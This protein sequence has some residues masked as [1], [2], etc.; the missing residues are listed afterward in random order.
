MPGY[1]QPIVLGKPLQRDLQDHLA[2]ARGPAHATLAG[3][4]PFEEA[5]DPQRRI[6]ETGAKVR[7]S[8]GDTITRRHRPLARPTGDRGAG[9]ATTGRE[10]PAPV[11]PDRRP[12]L[13]NLKICPQPLTRLDFIRGQ[14]RLTI[15]AFAPGEP[16]DGVFA[17]ID[18]QHLWPAGGG[19]DDRPLARQLM[20]GQE[21]CRDLGESGGGFTFESI[22]QQEPL[23]KAASI[24]GDPVTDRSE[25][26]LEHFDPTLAEELNGDADW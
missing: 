13:G 26:A 25:A 14:K 17:E 18:L 15:R 11:L 22:V 3:L 1:T 8:L 6:G 16:A 24:F 21:G 7:Q 12:H 23:E 10:K 5:T 9:Q 2:G 19:I 20:L 4:Q